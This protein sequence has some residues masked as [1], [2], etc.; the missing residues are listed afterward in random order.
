VSDLIKKPPINNKYQALKTRLTNQFTKSDHMKLKTLFSDLSLNDGKPSDLLRK[1]REKSCNKVGEE[2]LQE[3]W[4][5][6][7]PQQIQ[8]ILACSSE[9]LPQLVI[10]ADKIFETLDL[11]SIQAIKQQPSQFENDLTK[12]F[13]QLEDKIDSLQQVIDKS[14][15]RTSS[16]WQHRSKSRSTKQ[17]NQQNSTHCWYHKLFK[18][19]ARKCDSPCT[20]KDDQKNNSKN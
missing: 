11:T 16:P 3:L 15:S 7:L 1:M 10:M 19:K 8:S 18:D 2:L 13:C 5:N 4:S 20:F 17:K 9:P 14:R 12:H 6:R